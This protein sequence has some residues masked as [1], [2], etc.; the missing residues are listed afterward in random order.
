MRA[1]GATDVAI[2]RRRV[3]DGELR[4]VRSCSPPDFHWSLKLSFLPRGRRRRKHPRYPSWEEL[5]DARA[6]LLPTNTYMVMLVPVV[7]QLGP[8]VDTSFY[9]REDRNSTR[10]SP[11]ASEDL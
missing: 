9:L 11:E 7:E 2:L 6:Q 5:A 3:Y 4:A 8:V 1:T 10:K